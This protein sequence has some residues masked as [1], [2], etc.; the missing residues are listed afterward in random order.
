MKK[1][2]RNSKY[3]PLV[4]EAVLIEANPQYAHVRLEDGRETTLSLRDLAPYTP[5][6]TQIQTTCEESSVG[7]QPVTT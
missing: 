1:H 4:D 3:D 7:T 6:E 2:V 5:P